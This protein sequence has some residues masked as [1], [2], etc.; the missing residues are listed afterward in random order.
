MWGGAGRGLERESIGVAASRTGNA[1]VR[2]LLMETAWHYQHRP[3]VGVALVRRRKVAA[4]AGH[5]RAQT[6]RLGRQVS[7]VMHRRPGTASIGTPLKS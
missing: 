6:D 1:L 3:G 4:R 2:R 5:E 7:L